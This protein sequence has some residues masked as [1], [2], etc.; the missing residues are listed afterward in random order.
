MDSN[1]MF[2]LQMVILYQLD[3]LMM[4]NSSSSLVVAGEDQNKVVEEVLALFI[5]KKIYR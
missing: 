2:S 4:L 3:Q 1:I 5:T